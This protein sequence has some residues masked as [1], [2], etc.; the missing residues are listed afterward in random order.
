ML[1]RCGAP[2][3]GYLD[4]YGSAPGTVGE[5][6]RIPL[7]GSAKTKLNV[8]IER[9]RHTSYT[10]HFPQRYAYNIRVPT[11]PHSQLAAR[12]AAIPTYPPS[13]AEFRERPPSG[14]AQRYLP[15]LARCL[16][17]PRPYLPTL[18]GFSNCSGHLRA[19]GKE[20]QPCCMVH[21]RPT[22]RRGAPACLLLVFSA[23]GVPVPELRARYPLKS[24]ERG[25]ASRCECGTRVRHA[26]RSADRC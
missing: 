26:R 3:R 10:Y 4:W 25:R 22:T 12:S 24:S 7:G 19:L 6:S 2:T 14:R 20:T 15:T 21:G 13:G 1:R 16:P 17:A 18:A 5:R 9:S 11:Y 8:Y 23:A